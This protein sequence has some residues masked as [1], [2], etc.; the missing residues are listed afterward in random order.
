MVAV[1]YLGVDLGGTDVKLGVCTAEG[2]IRGRSVVPT[3]ATQGPE[4]TLDRISVAAH[5]LMETTGRAIACGAGTPGPLDPGRRVLLRATNLPGWTHVPF[6]ELLGQRLGIKTFLEND[7]NC[8]AW[9]EYR[10]GIGQGTNS[11][12]LFTLGT[13]VGG[14]IILHED[15][16]RGVNGGAGR[17][18]HVAVDPAGPPC[19]CGQRG[20]LEQYASATAVARRYGRG[21][22]K[23][24]F[25]AARRGEPIALEVV[26]W[27]CGALA[28]AVAGVIQIIQPEMVVLGGGMAAAGDLLLDRVRAGVQ[29]QVR[30]GGLE[31]IR[32]EVSALGRDAGWIGAALWAAHRSD[33]LT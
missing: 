30:V 4:D 18:G 19:G 3:L 6:P 7:A 23:E 16:W 8:A 29:Q 22:A 33:L 2:E 9:G 14:G 31:R 32:I 26:D 27:A 28:V 13:G 11:L 17:L 21:T 5:A 20:C 1:L 12:V 10:V 24:A 25:E 15:V